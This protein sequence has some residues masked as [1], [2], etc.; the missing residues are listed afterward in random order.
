MEVAVQPSSRQQGQWTPRLPLSLTGKSLEGS[1]CLAG[2]VE[3]TFR[4]VV[5]SNN[6]LENLLGNST[7]LPQ[8]AS[9]NLPPLGSLGTRC[10]AVASQGCRVHWCLAVRPALAWASALETHLPSASLLVNEPPLTGERVSNLEALPVNEHCECIKV[11]TDKG[12]EVDA[13]LVIV[14][15]GIKINSAAYRS[16]FGKWE[17]ERRAL[18]QGTSSLSSPWERSCRTLPQESALCPPPP[19]YLNS[20]FGVF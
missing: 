4:E 9:W 18:L 15:N 11:Q 2:L 7:S 1:S 14:C 16:T 6:L 3:C 10:P 17:A 12:T 8:V 5:S 20:S 13:N 19:P